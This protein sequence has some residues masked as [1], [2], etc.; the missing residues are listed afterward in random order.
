MGHIGKKGLPTMR[1]KGMVEGFPDCNLEAYFYEHCIY[2]KQNR[3]R[4]PSRAT[5]EKWIL[6]LIPSYVFGSTT[7]PSLGGSIYYVSFIDDF[8]RKTWIYLLRKE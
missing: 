6:Q 8:P 2:G 3:V 1:N 5:R 7:I 4:F